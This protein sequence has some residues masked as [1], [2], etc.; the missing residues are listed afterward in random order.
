MNAYSVFIVEHRPF[1]IKNRPWTVLGRFGSLDEAEDFL[2]Q[3]WDEIVEGLDKYECG[4][5]PT[6][7]IINQW[8]WGFRIREFK[9]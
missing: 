9:V 8:R 3:R 4:D 2:I 7:K 6:E 5:R 1:L